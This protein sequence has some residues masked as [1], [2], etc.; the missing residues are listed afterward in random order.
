MRRVSGEDLE[1]SLKDDAGAT[2]GLPDMGG[3]R[4][5]E[6]ENAAA[7]MVAG[8][9]ERRPVPATLLMNDAE[10]AAPPLRQGRDIAGA[11]LADMAVRFD[12]FDDLIEDEPSADRVR[13]VAV[14]GLDVQRQTARHRR[15]RQGQCKGESC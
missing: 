4:I 12:V 15:G 10:I 1:T 8:L 14:I 5:A 7:I 2:T 6:L 13:V 11:A 3:S 9:L